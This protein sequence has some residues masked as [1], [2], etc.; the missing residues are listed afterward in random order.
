[1]VL[2]SKMKKRGYKARNGEMPE[3]KF[4][5]R[6]QREYSEADTRL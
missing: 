4:S 5:P 1:M 2:T 3:N 6:L